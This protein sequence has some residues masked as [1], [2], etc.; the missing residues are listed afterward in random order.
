[1]LHAV[2]PSARY[3][4]DAGPM[5]VRQ[6]VKEK[7]RILRFM[8][9]LSF[10][11]LLLTG[12]AL[13]QAPIIPPIIGLEHLQSWRDGVAAADTGRDPLVVACF[14]DSNTEAPTYTVGLRALLQGCYGDR[15]LGYLTFMP[16]RGAIPGAPA[17]K[18]E[19]KWTDYDTSPGRNAP[20]PAPYWAMDGFWTGT[21]DANAAITVTH[22]AFPREIVYRN[23]VHYQTGPGLGAFSIFVG[24]WEAMRVDCAAEA[25][26]YGVTALF[27]AGQFRIGKVAGKVGL[28]GFDSNRTLIVRGEILTPGG[29]VVHALGNGWG[30]SVHLSPTDEAAFNAFFAAVKP[31][32]ITIMLGTNDMHNAG[33]VKWYREAMT[34]TIRKMQ[35]AAPGVGILVIACP[36]AGQ[37]RPGAAMEYAAAAKE[38]AAAN[39]CAFWDWRPLMGAKSNPATLMGYFGDG[40]HYNA[41]GGSVFSH[42]LLRQLGFDLNDLT[43]WPA[44]RAMPDDI[45]RAEITIPR[46]PVLALDGVKAALA[47][48]PPHTIW[49]VDRK[50]AEIRFALANDA[51]AVH[52]VVHDGRCLPAA[53]KWEQCN[54]DLYVSKIGSWA[55]DEQEKVG[56][57]GIVR[58]LV[59]RP[60]SPRSKAF[61]AHRSGKDDTAPDFPWQVTPLEPSGYEIVALIPMET[62]LLDAKTETFLLD[63]AAV[64]ASGPGAPLA[65]N[66]CFLRGPDTGAFRDNTTFAH[67]TVKEK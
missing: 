60:T 6:E 67:V 66:R 62:L 21:E 30:Q 46:L 20:P 57:H 24:D 31:D 41:L 32:L 35:R 18:R 16:G 19:G 22:A 28:L 40:L 56:Y 37:T 5:Y 15:G 25:P 27:L 7:T 58:Q 12:F 26:G 48:E 10:L 2:G 8:R 13:A 43:H 59:L 53:A 38:V 17:L 63:A 65:F 29:A 55:G 47:V 49:Q 3:P 52:A 45:A 61:S 14:G 50:V 9:Y 54:I 1:M 11:F 23:Q 39:K 33:V 64:T 51:L 4:R 44:L 42:L 34:T 36:E